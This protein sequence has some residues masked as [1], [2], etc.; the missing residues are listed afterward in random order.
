MEESS[1]HARETSEN[2]DYI[3]LK[4]SAKSVNAVLTAESNQSYRVLLTLNGQAL[5][6]ENKGQDVI[7]GD[8]G[9]SYLEVKEARLYVLVEHPQYAQGQELR[10]SSNSPDFGLYAFTFGVY[11]EGP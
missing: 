10:M 4:Y 7:I 1:R 5:T 11:K 9:N 8:D 2:E 3:D 6:E